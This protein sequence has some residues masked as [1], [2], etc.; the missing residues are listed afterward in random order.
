MSDARLA[1]AP[2]R[3]LRPAV[4]AAACYL[5]AAL[6]WVAFGPAL[7]GGRWLAVHL[8][9]VGVL[10]NLVVALTHHFAQTLLHAGTLD[11]RLGR[12]ALLNSGAVALLIGRVAGW[13]WLVALGGTALIA[14]V[15]W[16][17]LDLRR[18]RTAALAGR[19]TFVVRAY[20][21][22]CSAFFHGALLGI[23]MGVGVLAGDWYGA[24]RLAHLHVNILGWGGLTLLSTVV[25]F[26][27]TM[28]R[29]RL[30]PG[31]DTSAPGA[32]RSGATG[33]S[34]GAVALLLTGWTGG[35]EAVFRWLAVGGLAV[36]ATAAVRVCVPVLRAG[37]RAVPAAH[38]WLIQ[39]ACA[40][41]IFAVWA[42]VIAIALDRLWLLDALG[43]AL[44]AG[45]L[46]QA[47]LAALN[48]LSPLVLVAGAK[49]RAAARDVLDGAGRSRAVGLNLGVACLVAA[50]PGGRVADRLGDTLLTVG[51]VLL[52][53]AVVVQL[54]LMAWVPLRHPQMAP[55]RGRCPNRRQDDRQDE[56]APRSDR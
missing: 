2:F 54:L 27:P 18:Q 38:T 11:A 48:Y 25:F 45:V 51:W 12:F 5:L 6:A 55:D 37:A 40:W 16:L 41:F 21:R 3:H 14:A 23:L 49:A 26:G 1:L 32:L 46:G 19:F 7:P 20:E 50:I 47:I 28:M 4:A 56:V 42:D 52:A 33:L 36:Y 10:T 8:F 29:T 35:P 13:T 44:L 31:A 39:G 34:I 9:T 22:A 53:A 17:Y 24:A 15:T 43:V 30:E